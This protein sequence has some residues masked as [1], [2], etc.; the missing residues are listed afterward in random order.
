M[1]SDEDPQNPRFRDLG[2]GVVPLPP[3]L[4]RQISDS[5]TPPETQR[6]C[7]RIMDEEC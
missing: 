5:A 3:E 4:S 7:T 1:E 2:G 6:S